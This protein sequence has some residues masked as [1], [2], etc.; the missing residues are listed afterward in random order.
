[1]GI[2]VEFNPDLALRNISEHKNGNRQEDECIL[3]KLEVGKT[4]AFLKSGQRNY[5]LLGQIPLVETK[6][7]CQISRPLAAVEILE[8]TH[9]MLD[10]KLF[11]KGKYNIVEAFD[12][13]DGKADFDGFERVK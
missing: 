6:G 10:G 2:Q 3:E 12:P 7:N 13:N 1:M 5:W 9:F 4:H 8:A 11:T